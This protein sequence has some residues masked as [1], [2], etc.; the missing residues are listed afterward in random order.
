MINDFILNWPNK[1]FF[2]YFTAVVF[3]IG[4]HSHC[5]CLRLHNFKGY[6]EGNFASKF[7]K[8]GNLPKSLRTTELES[9]A[10]NGSIMISTSP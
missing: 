7:T 9:D 10:K 4:V 5:G 6:S 2:A 8:K 1:Q 3:S